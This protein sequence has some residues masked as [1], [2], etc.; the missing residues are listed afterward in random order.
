MTSVMLV[1]MALRGTVLG[2]IT[3]VSAEAGHSYTGA[4]LELAES[5]AS[6]AAAAIENSRLYRARTAIARTLQ[7]SLPPAL[8]EVDGFELAAAYRA[9]GEGFEVGGDFYDVFDTAEDQWYAVIGDVCGKGAEAAAV[10]AMARYTIRAA[11]VRRRSPAA[12]LRLLSEAMVRQ[13]AADEGRF[14]TI[15]CLHLDVSRSPARV[16]VACGGHPLPVVLRADGSVEELG[17]A[18]TLLGLVDRPELQDRGG[19][20]APGDTVL[21][22]TDGLTEAGAPEQLWEPEDLLR[23]VGE[24]AGRSAQGIVDHVVAA[25]VATQPEPRDDIAVV[26]L[27]ARR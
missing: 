24:A 25:A 4:D 20:L 9:A 12:I 1:P 23:V 16:T 19:E 13:D 8:P 26:A 22:Y 10:T 18:G 21:L 3:F 7:A 27:Q 5:M 11:A 17:V 15:A 6:H 14:C 2:V